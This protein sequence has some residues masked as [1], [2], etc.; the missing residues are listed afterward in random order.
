MCPAQQRCFPFKPNKL[1]VE[2][3][4]FPQGNRGAVTKIRKSYWSDKR[5]IFKS[6]CLRNFYRDESRS[7]LR[8]TFQQV[9]SPRGSRQPGSQRAVGF[10][11]EPVRNAGASSCIGATQRLRTLVQPRGIK[12]SDDYDRTSFSLVCWMLG[13]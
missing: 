13:I 8:I 5:K 6:P 10:A 7:C 9:L 3:R 2:K 11:G 4:C 12:P 1:M